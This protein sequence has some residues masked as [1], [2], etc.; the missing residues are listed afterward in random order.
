MGWLWLAIIGAV[1]FGVLW[2]A[3]LAR[4]LWAFVG[5]A[6]MLGATGYAWQ[7]RAT[8]PGHPVKA[9]AEPIDVDPGLVELREAMLGRFTGDGAYMIAA[10]AMTRVGDTGSAVRV[11]LGGLEKYPQSLTLWTGLGSAYATHD[12]N[13]VSPPALF[14]FQHA[15]KL[16]PKH[17]APPFFLGLA[18]VRA[19]DF[20]AARP[21]WARAL[22]LS[23]QGAS[24]RKGIALR[25]NMLD[26]YLAIAERMQTQQR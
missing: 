8:L 9:D 2:R 11:V 24:Y 26:R 6:L 17:P 12:G 1:T 19:G 21:L 22:A 23:P 10:D 25:L 14:A 15:A 4:E 20:A 7:Q 3:G 5:A 16:A 18:Y 13:L